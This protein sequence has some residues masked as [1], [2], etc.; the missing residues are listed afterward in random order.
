MFRTAKWRQMRHEIVHARLFGWEAVQFW[1]T[2]TCK[3]RVYGHNVFVQ[4]EMQG[5]I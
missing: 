1:H 5:T 3:M 2:D 4:L